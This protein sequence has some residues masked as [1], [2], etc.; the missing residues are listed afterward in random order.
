MVYS[1]K[2]VMCLLIDGKI[3]KELENGMVFVPFGSEYSLRFR[4]KNNKRAVVKF[5]IDVENASGGGYII[6]PN[7][8]VDIHRF[9]HKDCSFKFVS[10][11]SEEAF[12]YG[13]NGPNLDKTKGLIEA[14]FYLEKNNNSYNYKYEKTWPETVTYWHNQTQPNQTVTSSGFEKYYTNVTYA[15]D[16]STMKSTCPSIDLYLDGATVEGK[17]TGQ[18]FYETCIETESDYVSVKMFLQG[19]S[20]VKNLKEENESLRKQIENEKNKNQINFLLEENKK[21]KEELNKIRNKN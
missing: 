19:C 11:D 17:T 5:T 21:L 18:N 13:K 4:N 9:A 7:S 15:C 12:D 14:R 8:F 1:N 10:L 6:G 3:Q 2:F 16:S 20:N